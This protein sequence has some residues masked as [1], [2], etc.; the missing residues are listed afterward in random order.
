[1]YL[2]FD[3]FELAASSE[4]WFS[5][6]RSEYYTPEKTHF[7]SSSGESN[8]YPYYK[9]IIGFYPIVTNNPKFIPLHTNIQNYKPKSRAYSPMSWYRA[10]RSGPYFPQIQT[11]FM[12]KKGGVYCSLD[13]SFPH[14]CTNRTEWSQPGFRWYQ[15]RALNAL[16]QLSSF[17]WTNQWEKPRKEGEGKQQNQSISC[18]SCFYVLS[19]LLND[20]LNPLLITKWLFKIEIFLE[21]ELQW[22]MGD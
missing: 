20:I 2:V 22:Q 11:N 9:E 1:M 19:G 14:H 13:G 4:W 10:L 12:E 7:T 3:V 8:F 17:C 21:Q 6:S 18:R 16:Y 5:Q 15:W